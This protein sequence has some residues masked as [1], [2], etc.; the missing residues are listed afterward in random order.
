VEANGTSGFDPIE[1]ELA[2]A[3]AVR[4]RF[5]RVDAAAPVPSPT[6]SLGRP[7]LPPLV[8]CRVKNTFV[9]V[10]AL[11]EEEGPGAGAGGGD[12]RLVRSDPTPVRDLIEWS[13]SV[14]SGAIL[15]PASAAGLRVLQAAPSPEGGRRRPAEGPE[16]SAGDLQTR[17]E[18]M[19]L[20]PVPHELWSGHVPRNSTDAVRD[21]P[22]LAGALDMMSADTRAAKIVSHSLD[23]IDCDLDRM[24]PGGLRADPSNLRLWPMSSHSCTPLGPLLASSDWCAASCAA[25]ADTTDSI[26][27]HV[28]EG[29]F[30]TSSAPLMQ[31]PRTPEELLG[32]T[33][34][35][36]GLTR[37]PQYN[38]QWCRIAAYDEEMQ[39]YVVRVL[40]GGG[41]E[42]PDIAKLRLENL[43][44]PPATESG[45]DDLT[46]PTCRCS[47]L[48]HPTPSSVEP[49]LFV[50]QCDIACVNSSWS[51]QDSVGK[52]PLHWPIEEIS[53]AF[54]IESCSWICPWESTPSPPTFPGEDLC[55]MQY[56]FGELASDGGAYAIS[57]W[58]YEFRADTQLVAGPPGKSLVEAQQSTFALPEFNGR[59][60]TEVDGCTY[61]SAQPMPVQSLSVSLGDA[62]GQSSCDAPLVSVSAVPCGHLAVAASLDVS[63]SPQECFDEPPHC[64]SLDSVNARPGNDSNGI[65]FC[66]HAAEKG[67]SIAPEVVTDSA[68][69]FM[70]ASNPC[71][72]RTTES[73]LCMEMMDSELISKSALE[74]KPCYFAEPEHASIDT[75]QPDQTASV[76]KASG[77]RRRRKAGGREASH[78]SDELAV[79]LAPATAGFAAGT[80]PREKSK[81]PLG[82]D[83]KDTSTAR[84]VEP[85]T[86]TPAESCVLGDVVKNQAQGGDSLS[87][88][89]RPVGKLQART[90]VKPVAWLP[91]L[92]VLQQPNSP[93]ASSACGTKHSESQQTAQ[94]VSPNGM[95]RVDATSE[96][97]VG[98]CS[99]SKAFVCTTAVVDAAAPWRP[100]LRLAAV[101]KATIVAGIAA[102]LPLDEG[103][104]G[105]EGGR[106]EWGILG[107]G[108]GEGG[109]PCASGAS[110]LTMPPSVA[111][112]PAKT[113]DPPGPGGSA[114]SMVT[115][116]SAG[117]H[118]RPTLRQGS[119]M[120]ADAREDLR[121]EVGDSGE[122]PVARSEPNSKL[123]D[124][125]PACET[126]GPG[127]PLGADWRP[128]LRCSRGG[129]MTAASSS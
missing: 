93:S 104:A 48:V 2:A 86:F 69:P 124:A 5:L 71:G 84:L 60:S 125:A 98:S 127:A 77:R 89:S 25:H 37:C 57:A 45:L 103:G 28:V 64:V 47:Q 61:A 85:V 35:I 118:W 24:S 30:F 41:G 108:K 38:G 100:T 55:P 88:S 20:A 7:G 39:R 14:L 51:L 106:G 117:R 53:T 17:V 110:P 129:A 33:A 46:S 3:G 123:P 11:D 32:R 50:P 42:A 44:F 101:D 59:P 72:D 23:T 120:R 99:S 12:P 122:P 13:S 26:V 90:A 109:Y 16:A 31:P 91:S 126:A 68:R 36:S 58:P 49:P 27:D 15:P 94:V 87:I 19:A 115:G 96:D 121:P 80:S 112:R 81:D 75:V 76:S 10:V 43:R 4:L 113:T 74:F 119:T 73:T 52:S 97:P 70:Q 92:G 6:L 18:V 111:V 95:V 107:G 82:A 21:I 83:P 114:P 116:F 62:A 105:G 56:V 63:I 34:I 8:R 9:D 22:R 79:S 128:R 66:Y 65:T 78:P 40:V 29:N 102:L 67:P 54:P 1:R